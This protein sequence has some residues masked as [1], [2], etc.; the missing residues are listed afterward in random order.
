LLLQQGA[1]VNAKDAMGVTPLHLAVQSED[2]MLATI[3]LEKGA[4]IHARTQQGET[5]LHVV[6]AQGRLGMA[7]VLVVHGADVN[8][9][10]NLG[11]LPLKLATL[12]NHQPLAH[13]LRTQGA[14]LARDWEIELGTRKYRLS[15]QVQTYLT[16]LGQSKYQKTRS[17]LI[18]EEPHFNATTQ[19]ALY[20][21][22]EQF[23]RDHPRLPSRTMFLAE[24]AE[25]GRPLSVEP[26]IKATPHPDEPLIRVVLRSFL[27]PAYMAYAWKYHQYGIPI[28]GT[29]DRQLYDASA[30]LW[31]AN[32][33]L[34]W[35]LSVVARNKSLA[36]TL[37]DHT[38]RYENP[39]LFAG[40]LHL[41]PLA[42]T[43]YE[44]AR[45]LGTT[46]M[47]QPEQL[48]YLRANDNLG[49]ADYLRRAKIGYTFM[50][51]M[52]HEP[53]DVAK[54]NEERYRELFQAQQHGRYDEYIHKILPPLLEEPG[55]TVSP[56]PEAAAQLIHA[57]ADV[58]REKADARA[59]PGQ[60]SELPQK[61]GY[62]KLQ[63][64]TPTT[65]HYVCRKPDGSWSFWEGGKKGGRGSCP[66][67][68]GGEIPFP[69]INNPRPQ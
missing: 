17:V 50:S 18:I 63:K 44:V 59:E 40:G 62:C 51:A 53:P 64:E 58:R 30:A 23:F 4:N 46:T 25:A 54:R 28:L 36:Q 12:Q 16:I 1:D 22:L 34:V 10:D 24:G 69:D 15:A 33:I 29:E 27:I 13:W 38:K 31:T 11:R 6:A 20:K 57:L 45:E 19:W 52:G 8:A 37:I 56:A 39:I 7:E 26:L 21:G 43:T 61:P 2:S 32:N 67:A 41:E 60:G 65:C 66:G 49:I 5:P 47:L 35:Q 48:Q 9:A 55:I 42:P 3:L 68:G 14:E